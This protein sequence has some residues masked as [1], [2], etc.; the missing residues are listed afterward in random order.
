MTKTVQVCIAGGGPAG[1]MLGLLLARAG[2]PVLVLEKHADFLRDFRGDTLHP[3]T[4]EIMHEL[5]VL[6]RFLRLPHQT[7]SRINGWFGELEFTVADFSYLPTQCRYVAFMPQWDFL[8]FLAEAGSRYPDFQVR[9]NAEV[10][11]LIEE[12]GLVVGLRAV[13]PDGPL[14]V[15]SALVVGADG[16]HSVVRA[17]AGLCVEEFG[18]PMDVLWFRLS[19]RPHDPIDPMGRFDIGRI[20]IMLNRGEYW[21]CGFVIAKGSLSEVHAKGLEAFRDSVAAL[22]PFAA[23][24]VHELREWDL[25]K[26]LTVQIDRLQRWYRPGLLCIGDAAHAMSPVAGVGI[27]LAIQDAVATANLLTSAL[28]DNRLT[29]EDLHRVQARRAWPT[30]MTQRV[31]LMIQNRV[32]TPVLATSVRLQP[33][34]PVR[35]IA[36]FPFLQRFPA[37]LIGL[38]FRPEHIRTP[39]V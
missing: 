29:V 1:M 36:R 19:R 35:L 14:E 5:G 26:L 32:I 9:M 20:F 24:R 39:A 11:D 30:K 10:T 22:A 13:T 27:N 28:R 6:E 33:P 18:A 12:S 15:R 2:V 23:D 21:Q 34:V 3:S 38:G 31:Q 37:R 16:R 8:N 25:I 7:V 4:L 17:K